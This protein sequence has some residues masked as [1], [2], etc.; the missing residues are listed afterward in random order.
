MRRGLSMERFEVAYE[1]LGENPLPGIDGA[2]VWRRAT[3]GHCA[4]SVLIARAPP[5]STALL[6]RPVSLSMRH[7]SLLAI[8]ADLQPIA[9]SGGTG[10]RAAS[11]ARHASHCRGAGLP[12][13]VTRCGK[14]KYS[15]RARR[16]RG[17]SADEVGMG[18]ADGLNCEVRNSG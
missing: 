9:R 13:E 1:F 7:S 2:A 18:R 16:G 10:V 14:R 17:R 8:V 6:P 5:Q 11:S 15:R 3:P 4:R 12:S